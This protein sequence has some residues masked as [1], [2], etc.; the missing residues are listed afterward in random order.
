MST[1]T[2]YVPGDEVVTPDG[3]VVTVV[4]VHP[5]FHTLTP[6]TAHHVWVIDAPDRSTP[7]HY[8]PDDL[9]PD[10]PLL[11]SELDAREG[12]RNHVFAASDDW[13]RNEVRGGVTRMRPWWK[14]E[15]ALAELNRRGLSAEEVVAAKGLR[16]G[17][18]ITGFPDATLSPPLPLFVHEVDAEAE[19]LS[20][21]VFRSAIV[22]T[23]DSFDPGEG[24]HGDR[25]TISLPPDVKVE[26]ER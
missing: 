22:V 23:V 13:V 21:G 17:D 18:K 12:W 15:L 10:L 14:V 1:P 25:S 3:R 9:R 4:R 20:D 11:D 5:D 2:T 26:V 8:D 6:A 24:W 16:R 7:E 19:T